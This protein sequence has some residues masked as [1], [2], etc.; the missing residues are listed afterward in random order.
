MRARV[1][2]PA[3]G[4]VVRAERLRSALEAGVPPAFVSR[5]NPS[6]ETDLLWKNR[7][8]AEA[9]CNYLEQIFHTAPDGMTVL[10]GRNRAV[11]VNQAFQTMFGYAPADLLG[12]FNRHS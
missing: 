10:D 8:S 5:D 3:S 4:E 7:E 6:W 9:R 2:R 1:A 11:C 12:K